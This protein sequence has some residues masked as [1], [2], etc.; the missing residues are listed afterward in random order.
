MVYAKSKYKFIF[1]FVLFVC[2]YVNKEFLLKLEFVSKFNIN[3]NF[4]LTF[5]YIFLY[6]EAMQYVICK[7][8]FLVLRLISP[9]NSAISFK[10]IYIIYLFHLNKELCDN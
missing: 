1:A 9:K 10:F 2:I 7:T 3:I 6:N 4:V 5:I 8:D